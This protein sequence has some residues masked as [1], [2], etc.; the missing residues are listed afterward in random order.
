VKTH[1]KRHTGTATHASFSATFEHCYLA[2]SGAKIVECPA[3][4][5]WESV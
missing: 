1:N 5:H 2:V 3:L 4:R